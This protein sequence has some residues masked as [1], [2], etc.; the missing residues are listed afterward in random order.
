MRCLREPA[1]RNKKETAERLEG[2]S[3]LFS[4]FFFLI[5]GINFLLEGITARMSHWQR[6]GNSAVENWVSP[7]PVAALGKPW[8][9][10]DGASGAGGAEDA[11]GRVSDVS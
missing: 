4:F 3:I 1:D 7:L 5:D 6:E 9:L 10:S 11:G 2:L 8:R